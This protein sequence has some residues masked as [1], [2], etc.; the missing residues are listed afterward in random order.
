[1][2]GEFLL[3]C[4]CIC[5]PEESVPDKV[6]GWDRLSIPSPPYSLAWVRIRDYRKF[7]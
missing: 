4:F 2:S 3:L 5:S 7:K 1:M 6:W